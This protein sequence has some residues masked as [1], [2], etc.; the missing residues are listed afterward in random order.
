MPVNTTNSASSS[1]ETA[2][3]NPNTVT[4]A[5]SSASSTF[6]INSVSVSNIVLPPF[7]Y[8]DYP[9][10]LEKSYYGG[11]PTSQF[12]VTTVIVGS[13]LKTVEGK[14][15]VRYFP[16]N[17]A[18]ISAVAAQRNYENVIKAL[19]GAKVNTITPTD[20]ALIKQAGGIDTLFKKLRLASAKAED[21]GV[22][23]F[24]Q[25]LIRSDKANIWIAVIEENGGITTRLV[26]IEE[27]AMEQ[28]VG[29]IK[30]DAM[31]ASLQSQGHI[32]LYLSFD[33]DSDV[34]KIDSK[35][36]VGEIVKLLRADEKLHLNIEGHTDNVGT[37]SH[38]KT[39]SQARAQAVVK[40][41]TAQGINPARLSAIGIG[42]ERP[43]QDNS[44]EAGRAKNRRVEL[45]KR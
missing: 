10:T 41:I 20:P 9:T 25:Y 31:A 27:K 18:N 23:V 7:P 13:E 29:L 24:D 44:S 35:P 40:A 36:V 26:T 19:G 3:T 14:V 8:V 11:L 28:S 43:L 42:A 32:A 5:Q 39:L 30:A 1:V 2:A 38:N 45:V 15:S 4:P 16:N 33:T 22:V 37:A 21:P 6:D 12:D 34:I 17:P